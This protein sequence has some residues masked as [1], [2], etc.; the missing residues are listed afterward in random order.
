MEPHG[1]LWTRWQGSLALVH[2]TEERRGRQQEDLALNTQDITRPR[3]E[4]Y[5]V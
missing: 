2:L 1:C 5:N 3:G 4:V